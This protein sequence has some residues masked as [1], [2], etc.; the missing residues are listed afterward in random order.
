MYIGARPVPQHNLSSTSLHS[1]QGMLSPGSS[2]PTPFSPPTAPRQIQ[3]PQPTQ[4]A[5]APTPKP[6]SPSPIRTPFYP[7]L[8]WQS[9]EGTFAPRRTKKRRK[10][11]EL[12]KSVELPQ[13]PEMKENTQVMAS[14]INVQSQESTTG[15]T[16]SET[17]PTSDAPSEVMSTQ[18]TTPT[19]SVPPQQTTPKASASIPVAIPSVS[20][21]PAVPSI[22][23]P[24]R[25][26]KKV[27]ASLASDNEKSVAPVGQ[28][29][30]EAEQSTASQ[31]DEV[32]SND[33]AVFQKPEQPAK[34]PPKS[35]ADLLKSK[36]SAQTAP[37]SN[38]ANPNR[39]SEPNG[40]IS[41]RA[42]SLADVLSSFN[43]KGNLDTKL[44]FI[45]PRG[46][47]NSGN[48]CYMNSVSLSL[49]TFHIYLMLDRFCKV[50]CFVFL[51]MLSWIESA[52]KPLI[53]SKV[54]PP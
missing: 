53:V 1:S 29:G 17:P 39:A 23:L 30:Q 12:S 34:V 31:N 44:A 15:P 20:I 37:S 48:M 51:S 2:Q 6:R 26:R 3:S 4:V 18:P 42:S 43:V 38:A 50:S 9:F 16:S 21:R 41:T 11:R 14:D 32:A 36:A 22:P 8:P 5:Q 10:P 13:R 52:N 54:I 45:E 46:L 7:P 47:V 49:S 40:V 33:A 28:E 27:S 24:S 25:P 35:W 19:S